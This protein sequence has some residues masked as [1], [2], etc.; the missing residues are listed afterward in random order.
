MKLQQSV[1]RGR[2]LMAVD[3]GPS[4]IKKRRPPSEESGRHRAASS[5]PPS[6]SA[7]ARGQPRRS[8]H[9]CGTVPGYARWR[10]GGSRSGCR[11]RRRHER[12]SRIVPATCHRVGPTGGREEALPI[13]GQEL[14]EG[15]PGVEV[16][17]ET[18]RHQRG[19]QLAD[20][21]H[22]VA[23][24]AVTQHATLLRERAA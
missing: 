16:A 15:R 17:W 3:C 7:S 5:Q 14:R 2:C 8:G 12:H 18:H 10:A 6:C 20:S 22:A 11:R 1:L 19:T 24:V 21:H 23:G 13:D 4:Y 9:R